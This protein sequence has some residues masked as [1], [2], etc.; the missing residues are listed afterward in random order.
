MEQAEWKILPQAVKLLCEE[1]IV[2]DGKKTYI[3]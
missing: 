1:R 2:I 3:K